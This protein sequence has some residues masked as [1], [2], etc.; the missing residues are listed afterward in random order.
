MVG[1]GE[2]WGQ[3]GAWFP[4]LPDQLPPRASSCRLV[5]CVSLALGLG[6]WHVGTSTVTLPKGAGDVE[7]SLPVS[8]LLMDD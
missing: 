6:P 5:W 8:A 4:G 2:S 1:K 3:I 7:P